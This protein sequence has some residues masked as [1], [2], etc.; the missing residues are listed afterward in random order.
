M[1]RSL[2]CKYRDLLVAIYQI[3]WETKKRSLREPYLDFQR[4]RTKRDSLNLKVQRGSKECSDILKCYLD[5]KYR[6]WCYNV[7]NM[8]GMPA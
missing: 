5:W 6:T 2:C 8:S 1:F 3:P 4:V 7:C